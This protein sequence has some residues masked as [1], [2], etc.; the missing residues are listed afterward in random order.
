MV[1]ERRELQLSSIHIRIMQLIPYIACLIRCMGTTSAI[2]EGGKEEDGVRGA[3]SMAPWII[4]S[5]KIQS[6]PTTMCSANQLSA[7]LP[8]RARLA[9]ESAVA[10]AVENPTPAAQKPLS[11]VFGSQEERGA[12]LEAPPAG[13]LLAL[14]K[15]SWRSVSPQQA[16]QMALRVWACRPYTRRGLPC[17]RS[18]ARYTL[19]WGTN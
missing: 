12:A 7:F 6:S 11:D 5:N 18:A 2:S 1:E 10:F 3:Q 13:P 4:F 17:D 14:G 16:A 19:P 8:A 9:S 15:D